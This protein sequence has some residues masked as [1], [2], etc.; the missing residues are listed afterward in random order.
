MTVRQL[1]QPPTVKQEM[2]KKELNQKPLIMRNATDVSKSTMAVHRNSNGLCDG[3]V[4]NYVSL[5]TLS[6]EHSIKWNEQMAHNAVSLQQI[7]NVCYKTSAISREI[8]TNSGILAQLA[9]LFI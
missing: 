1:S 8:N 3:K 9:E 7:I 2:N 5:F 6:A 4:S